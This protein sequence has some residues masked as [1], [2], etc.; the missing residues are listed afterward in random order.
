MYL[1]I[2]PNF[3][4]VDSDSTNSYAE[5]TPQTDPFYVYVAYQYMEW[6]KSKIIRDKGEN[7]LL[8]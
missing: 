5:D 1:K 7:V 3:D 2:S 4:I 6:Y 8:P